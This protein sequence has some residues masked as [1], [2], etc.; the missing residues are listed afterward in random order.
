MTKENLDFINNNGEKVLQLN[1]DIFKN[2]YA[3]QMV[4]FYDKVEQKNN[5]IKLKYE[6]KSLNMIEV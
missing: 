6:S 4:E 3:P 1:D 5:K 2:I